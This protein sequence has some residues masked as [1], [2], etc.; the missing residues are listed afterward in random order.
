MRSLRSQGLLATDSLELELAPPV[1]R[2]RFGLPLLLSAAAHAVLLAGIA[3]G[4]LQSEGNGVWPDYDE[5][6]EGQRDV[7]YDMPRQ[8]V[9]RSSKPVAPKTSRVESPA[10]ASPVPAH[11]SPTKT[12]PKPSQKPAQHK[13]LP[14]LKPAA[15]SPVTQAKPARA[16]AAKH[17]SPPKPTAKPSPAKVSKP[18]AKASAAHDIKTSATHPSPTERKANT[19]P[20]KPAAAKPAPKAPQLDLEALSKMPAAGH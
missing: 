6:A 15:K 13:E 16:Q 12:A 2:P 9:P 11:P 14:P 17:D 18:V 19:S 20:P 3:L 8:T 7:P 5:I 10:N 4:S 1:E